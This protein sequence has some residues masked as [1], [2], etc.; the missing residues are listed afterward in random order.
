MKL[1]E[2]HVAE[3]AQTVREGFVVEAGGRLWSAAGL[4]VHVGRAKC[5]GHSGQ[6]GDHCGCGDD[7]D[8]GGEGEVARGKAGESCSCCA[9]CGCHDCHCEGDH[10]DHQPKRGLMERCHVQWGWAWCFGGF[11]A[12][13]GLSILLTELRARQW[14]LAGVDAVGVDDE[15]EEWHQVGGDLAVAGPLGVEGLPLRWHVWALVTPRHA[16]WLQNWHTFSPVSLCHGARVSSDSGRPATARNGPPCVSPSHLTTA[17]VLAA[18]AMQKQ[19]AAIGS[20]P[21]LA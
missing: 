21:V 4:A 8:G 20:V 3:F 19:M 15:H 1:L 9:A 11:V 12:G 13:V 10:A 6:E 17:H 16:P 14:S 2:G 18:T 5:G 7:G